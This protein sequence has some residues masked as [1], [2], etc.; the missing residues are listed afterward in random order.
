MNLSSSTQSLLPNEQPAR[1]SHRAWWVAGLTLVGVAIRLIMITQ[2]FVDHWDWRESDVAM[3]ARNFYLHG[4]HILHPQIDWIGGAPG[5]VGTEFPLVSFIAAVFYKIFGLHE[6]IGRSVSVAF[7]A[8]SVPFLFGL[9]ARLWNDR[10]ALLATGVY[11]LTPL[12]V[13]TGRAFMP[14]MPSLSCSIAALYLFMCWLERDRS[15]WLFAASC[16]AINLAILIKLPAII[17]GLPMLYM[18]W[19]RYRKQMLAQPRLWALAALS[20]VPSLAWYAYAKHVAEHNPPNH[21]F[22]Q[23]GVGLVTWARY[24]WILKSTRTENLGPMVFV[25]MILGLFVPPRKRYGWMFHWWF[26]AGV[27]FVVLAGVGNRHP[28]YRL[29]LVPSAAAFSGVLI[30]QVWRWIARAIGPAQSGTRFQPVL[31]APDALRFPES[32][33]AHLSTSEHGQHGRATLSRV[34]IPA[35]SLTILFGALAITCYF[36]AHTPYGPWAVG[37]MNAGKEVAAIAP[38]GALVI[39]GDG[40]DPQCLYYSGHKG[41]HFDGSDGSLFGGDPPDAPTLIR[42]LET[43]RAQGGSYLVLPQCTTMWWLENQYYPGFAD[44]LDTHYIRARQTPDYVIFDIRVDRIGPGEK[45]KS[46]ARESK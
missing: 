11:L 30:D 2:P 3:I 4:F 35:L 25:G 8:I 41:F 1:V 33:T 32:P 9:V 27:A 10:A 21:F 38:P 12:S 46:D 19:E 29:P 22:G 20:L 40:G 17:I 5:Y 42:D 14:D 37:S 39:T 26:I 7:F 16:A 45:P 18:V 28:W 43:L 36:F 15:V 6:W 13:L 23:G 34:L 31:S 24:K 44:Y